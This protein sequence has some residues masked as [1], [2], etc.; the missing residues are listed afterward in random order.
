MAM[1]G[2]PYFFCLNFL[3]NFAPKVVFVQIIMP[4]DRDKRVIW[5][6]IIYEKHSMELGARE[7]EAGGGGA[8]VN[9]FE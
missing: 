3:V 6:L 8:I 1:L 9:N 4:K 7:A 5:E 2:V